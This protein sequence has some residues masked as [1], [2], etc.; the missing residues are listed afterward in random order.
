MLIP[1]DTSPSSVVDLIQLVLWDASIVVK[2][3]LM[4]YCCVNICSSDSWE[5]Y[6]D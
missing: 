6:D 3:I 1:S 5:I 2:A 4:T